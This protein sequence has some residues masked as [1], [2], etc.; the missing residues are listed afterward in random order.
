MTFW[1]LAISYWIHLLTTVI[2][3]GGM[4]LMALVAWPALR[5]GSLTDNQWLT[6]QQKFLPY[7]N[8]SLILLLLT[9]FVQ[10]TN[11]SNY[12]GFLTVDSVWAWAIL[13]KHIAFIGMV[14]IGGLVQGGLYPAMQR[15]RLLAANRPDQAAAEQKI[16]QQKEIRYLRLNLICAVLVLLCTAVATAV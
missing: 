5:Q 16:L 4:A 14:V 15:T 7:A 3:L 8:A 1:I 6:L 2:W 10:M 12:N 13:V 11:D 9:G